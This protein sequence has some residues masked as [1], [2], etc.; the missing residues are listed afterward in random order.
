MTTTL[1]KMIKIHSVPIQSVSIHWWFQREVQIQ[2]NK[3][4]RDSRVISACS[5]LKAFRF[6]ARGLVFIYIILPYT[7]VV[8]PGFLPLHFFHFQRVLLLQNGRSLVSST[9]IVLFL[10]QCIILDT[11]KEIL[12]FNQ[13]VEKWHGS[14]MTMISQ[15]THI[16][17]VHWNYK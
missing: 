1:L 8:L 9:I 2:N 4:Q 16:N 12:M 14:I 7:S 5:S 17:I 3:G 10:L 13:S 11:S 6:L 15:N